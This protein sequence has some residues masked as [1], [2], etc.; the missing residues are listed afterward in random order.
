MNRVD[1]TG[2]DDL[3]GPGFPNPVDS[4]PVTLFR[5]QAYALTARTG[6]RVEGVVVKNFDNGTAWASL[7]A[8]V[9]ALHGYMHKMLTIAHPA[10]A[11][12]ANFSPFTA[13]DTFRGTE[14]WQAIDSM[15]QF[16]TWLREALSSDQAHAV[17]ENLLNYI[18]DHATT[19]S[20]FSRSSSTSRSR[21]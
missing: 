8:K 17:V 2:G 18:P 20:G 11:S 14:D 9:P 5:Q 1:R 15:E 4:A 16:T 19:S 13:H 21:D 6:G 12:P 10:S 7:Y 3:W